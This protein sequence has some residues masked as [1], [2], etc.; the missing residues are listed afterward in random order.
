MTA[1]LYETWYVYHD[2][3]VH[4]N[5]VLHKSGPLVCM[6]IIA[7]QRLC[8]NVTAATNTQARKMNCWTRSFLCGPCRFKERRRLVLP[9]TSCL[10]LCYRRVWHCYLSPFT[11]S[12]Y[13]NEQLEW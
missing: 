9:R 6:C 2:A 11:S 12:Q 3:W 13:V 8:E 5:A 4:L 1:N 7:G 10:R